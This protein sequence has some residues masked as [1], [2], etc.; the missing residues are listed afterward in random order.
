MTRKEAIKF[1]EKVIALGLKDET[2]MFC[3]M[4]IAALKTKP[5]E[6]AVSRT[7]LLDAI[8]DLDA[9]FDDNFELDYG[10]C[11]KTDLDKMA[12]E[13]PPVTP[14]QRTGKWILNDNQGVQAVGYLTYHCSECGREISSKYHGKTSLLNE[15]PYCHCGA[16]MEEGSGEE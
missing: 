16:K 6:D 4:A 10:R 2:Q 5:C 12:M 15:Y 13:L 9:A 1:G 14:K 8:Y 3:E 11:Y 7:D